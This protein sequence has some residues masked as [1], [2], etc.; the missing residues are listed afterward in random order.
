ML[1]ADFKYIIDTFF[2]IFAMTLIIFMVPGFAMLEAGLVRTKNVSAVL[3]INVMI[4][5]VASLAFLLVGYELAF[6][7]WENQT[8]SIWAFFMFQMAFV[9]K[10]VNIMSG[11]VSE[12]VRIIPLAIFTAVMGA[13]IYP[14]VV[15]VSW[16]ADMIK[17]TLFDIEMYDLAGSTV[18]HSTGGWALLAAIMIIGSRKGRY[19]DG[20]IRVIPASNIPLVV[21]GALL[22]WIG[23]FGFNGGSVGS[24]STIENANLVAKT[25]MN[26]NTAGLAGAIIAGI[27]MYVRYKLL[28]ITMILNGALGGLVAITAAANFYDMY[29]PILIGLVGGALV[30]FAVPVFDKFKLDDP[31][32]ALSVHLVNGIWGTLA[33]GIF[34]ESISFT[35]QLKGVV[36]V[37]IFTFSVS[38]I[39]LYLINKISNFR[40]SDDNQLEGMDINECGVEAYPEFKRAI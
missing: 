20:K 21:L 3:T 22:L 11:G 5:A 10:T 29:T 12:R 2:T 34:V 25:I 40:A 35:A 26:T 27:I 31:V 15:N 23:W 37:G 9:G 4:Y 8:Q 6:G 13:V 18:I 16:G 1:E 36:L 39:V 7:G 33:A 14:L 38:Y 30:V 32:G 24:I 17:G 19:V 28:D